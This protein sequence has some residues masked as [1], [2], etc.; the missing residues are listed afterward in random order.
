MLN[1]PTAIVLSFFVCHPSK[2]MKGPTK[3]QNQQEAKTRCFRLLVVFIGDCREGL[4]IIKSKPRSSLTSSML[5]AD[6]PCLPTTTV[7]LLARCSLLFQAIPMLSSFVASGTTC[8]AVTSRGVTA[9]LS[10]LSRWLKITTAHASMHACWLCG[11]NEQREKT[12]CT[13][14]LLGTL[15]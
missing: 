15:S 12:D 2:C 6:I 10:W 7:W 8:T 13:P 14:R 1:L 4:Q 11:S 9:T 5:L 3:Y